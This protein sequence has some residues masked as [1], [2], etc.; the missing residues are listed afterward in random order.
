MKW[1]LAPIVFLTLAVIV[2]SII[3]VSRTKK[4]RA[5]TTTSPKKENLNRCDNCRFL[6]PNGFC[7]EVN[8]Y[9]DRSGE[10]CYMYEKEKHRRMRWVNRELDE[11][12]FYCTIGN[13]TLDITDI[14]RDFGCNHFEPIIGCP[15]TNENH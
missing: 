7:Y 3:I 5:T 14:Q 1:E 15:S 9:V 2:E 11:T 12:Q 10:A 6:L 13:T 8:C 4:I